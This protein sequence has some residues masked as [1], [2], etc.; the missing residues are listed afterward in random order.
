MNFE[1]KNIPLYLGF[2]LVVVVVSQIGSKVGEYF[3]KGKIDDEYD[4]IRKY[5]LNDSP[6]YAYNKPKLWIHTKYEKNSRFWTSFS[7]RSTYDLNQ[8][9]IHLTVKSIIDHC[10]DDFNICLIDDDS[11]TKL[12]PSFNTN[13]DTMVEPFKLF[14]QE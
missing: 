7:S 3:E 12:L 10:G 14:L 6:L 11:F 1:K 2:F 8:P 4:L 5:L 9:Y 13:I